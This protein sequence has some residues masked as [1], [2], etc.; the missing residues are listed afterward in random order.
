MYAVCASFLSHTLLHFPVILSGRIFVSMRLLILDKSR[1][2][3]FS[4]NFLPALCLILQSSSPMNGEFGNTP[5]LHRILFRAPDGKNDV[6]STATLL[7]GLWQKWYIIFFDKS[8]PNL[9]MRC[10]F[11]ITCMQMLATIG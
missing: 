4:R 11:W 3:G 10:M 6:R 5:L 9:A 2:S 8:L 7:R 1:S